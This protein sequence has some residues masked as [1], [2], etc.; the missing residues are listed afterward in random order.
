MQSKDDESSGTEASDGM[1][2]DLGLLEDLTFRVQWPKMAFGVWGFGFGF[3]PRC[4]SIATSVEALDA[5]LVIQCL[6]TFVG[7]RQF[8]LRSKKNVLDR[9]TEGQPK[10]KPSSGGDAFTGVE[11][12]HPTGGESPSSHCLNSKTRTSLNPRN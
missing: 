7:F 11:N 12:R 5:G 10:V 4:I 2:G 6:R 9:N 1:Q 8:R 3:G